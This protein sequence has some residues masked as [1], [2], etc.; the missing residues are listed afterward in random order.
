MYPAKLCPKVYLGG[1]EAGK[2]EH[3][4]RSRCPPP[5]PVCTQDSFSPQQHPHWL[6]H[7]IYFFIFYSVLFDL[8]STIYISC[9]L[10]L[11]FVVLCGHNLVNCLLLIHDTPNL[12]V[13]YT[14]VF[15][16]S[17]WAVEKEKKYS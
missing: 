1:F 7:F 4:A 16:L 10:N 17:A 5:P 11:K 6:L 13:Y 2:P 14:Y 12:Y 8:V 9:G 15:L 3:S